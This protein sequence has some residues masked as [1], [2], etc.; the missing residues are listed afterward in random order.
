MD[1]RF[2]PYQSLSRAVQCM[3]MVATELGVGALQRRV[4]GRLGLLDAAENR[5]RL[6][7]R[8]RC[9][10]WL[11]TRIV[12]IAVRLARLIVLRR[13]LG[14]WKAIRQIQ[15]CCEIAWD[16]CEYILAMAET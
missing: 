16:G 1:R 7:C 6:D 9:W 13:V 3:A 15:S 10:V 2:A 4:P 12:P 14:L 8:N 11:A 5:V